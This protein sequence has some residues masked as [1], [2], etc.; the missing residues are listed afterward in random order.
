MTRDQAIDLDHNDNGIGYL[1]FSHAVCNRSTDGPRPRGR[2]PVTQ[3]NPKP[4]P[5]TRW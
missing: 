3:Y 1:G 4:L 5:A 2:G